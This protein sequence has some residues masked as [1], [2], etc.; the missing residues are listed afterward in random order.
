VRSFEYRLYPTQGQRTR[1]IACLMAT[2]GL[3]NEMLER[4]KA[5]HAATDRFLS[6]YALGAAF[7][8]RGGETVPATVVQALADRLDKA[9]RRYVAGRVR[10]QP[11]GFPRF[12]GPTRWHSI[13]LRQAGNDFRLAPDGKRLGIAAKLGGPVK[14]KQHRPLEGTPKTAHLVLRADGHWYVLIVCAPVAAEATPVAST[15]TERE[16]SSAIGLDVGLRH[17]PADSDGNTVADP[18]HFRRTERTL[19]RQQRT[20]SRRK[21]GSRRRREAAR[22][23]A[24]THLTVARQRRGFHFKT[25]KGYAERYA[26]IYAED[27]HIAGMA[28]NRRLAK[29]ISDA[30]WGAF[31]VILQ[32]KAAGAGHA[33][34]RVPAHGT[35]QQCS[36]CRELVPKTLS[37]RT[38]VCTTC[39]YVADR[40]TNAARNI[41]ARGLELDTAGAQPS[42][43][44][45]GVGLGAA[46]SRRF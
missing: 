41:L 39:G 25:A 35:S 20:L 32:D 18:Q 43:R 30:S 23:V 3:Y 21:R 46:R 22:L 9:L 31:L 42:S 34:V 1:L 24:R 10:G 5:H 17:F 19:R 26:R 7:K 16:P 33:V 27:L 45:Q 36:R 29:S 13:R 14:L 44:N 40:D 28:R 11:G 38:H 8:G 4:Q 6:E 12:K 37:V 15:S 2:R